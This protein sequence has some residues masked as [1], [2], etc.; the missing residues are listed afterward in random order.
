MQREYSGQVLD[1]LSTG[2]AITILGV[3]RAG[4]S[5]I[6]T[7]VVKRLVDSGVNP[8]N[9]LIVNFEDPGSRR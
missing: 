9:I 3:K 5:T 1:L 6:I 8:L 7:Q 2:E 4:K